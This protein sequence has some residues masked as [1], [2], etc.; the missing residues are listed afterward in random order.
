LAYYFGL[1]LYRSARWWLDGDE[2]QIILND[3]SNTVPVRTGNSTTIGNDMSLSDCECGAGPGNG[4]G[5]DSQCQCHSHLHLV[6]PYRVDEKRGSLM[7]SVIQDLLSCQISAS[8]LS[9]PSPSAQHHHHHH[10]H[11][12]RDNEEKKLLRP[13]YDQATHMKR[14]YSVFND[15]CSSLRLA[16]NDE[17]LDRPSQ[18]SCQVPCVFA[19]DLGKDEFVKRF[20]SPNMPVLIHYSNCMKSWR[21]SKEFVCKDIQFDADSD[22]LNEQQQCSLHQCQ[23][24]HHST[25]F[26]E[27]DEENSDNVE[28]DDTDTGPGRGP[29]ATT[30]NDIPSNSHAT[31]H[32]TIDIDKMAEYFGDAQV[33]VARCLERE[34]SDQKRQMMPFDEYAERWRTAGSSIIRAEC[35]YYIKDWH[36]AREFPQLDAY[37]VPVYFEDDLLNQSLRHRCMLTEALSIDSKSEC[38]EDSEEKGSQ[39]H[40]APNGMCLP[41]PDDDFRFMYLGPMGSWTPCHHDVYAS[42]SWSAN[43]C[44]FKL[45]IMFPPEVCSALRDQSSDSDVVYDIRDATTKCDKSRFPRIVD[46]ALANC[47]LCIQAPG[48][49]IFV[50]SGWYH[51]VHNLTDAMSINHNWF[52]AFNIDRV[53]QHL[54]H[55]FQAA[56]NELAAFSDAAVTLFPTSN[57]QS[58]PETGD[59]AVAEYFDALEFSSKL[60]RANTGIHFVDFF[61]IIETCIITYGF[62][63]QSQE[64]IQ[65]LSAQRI[66]EIVLS[67][68]ALPLM[69]HH[70]GI[71]RM[72][73]IVNIIQSRIKK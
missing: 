20:M 22:K 9:S 21:A 59:K 28:S 60:M 19:A 34:Y 54:Q 70:V 6:R 8:P 33:C 48:D 41:A 55:E 47:L 44:G 37:Q 50:P 36:F 24:Q 13:H 26:P 35:P 71:V 14:V 62:L 72:M 58:V 18:R 63:E 1:G 4:C 61:A 49:V 31:L 46:T 40:D 67:M 2:E 65:R 17:S 23:C 56:Y 39:C 51:Q 16:S 69:Q 64:S 38:C 30:R 45:W 5:D 53:W 11:Q 68:C 3:Y 57:S 27:P 10:H 52:N 42:Y 15:V 29:S 73:R 25:R 7:C 43:V 12:P 66:H 32:W